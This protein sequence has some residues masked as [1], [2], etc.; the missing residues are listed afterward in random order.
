MFPEDGADEA[1]KLWE[2]AE[3]VRTVNIA[4]VE[5]TAAIVRRLSGRRAQT[6]LHALVSRW[7]KIDVVGVSDPLVDEAA[8]FAARYRLRALDALHLAAA[9]LASDPQLVMATWD[10]ELRQAAEAVGL[11]T[12]P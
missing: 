8:T 12:A 1:Y 5:A 2:G 11:A 10:D 6:A 3:Q 7:Q 9:S 4:Y